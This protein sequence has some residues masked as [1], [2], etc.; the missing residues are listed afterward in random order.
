MNLQTEKQ[1]EAEELRQAVE[2]FG[3]IEVVSG[4]AGVVRP[5]PRS[6]K[7]DPTTK[8]KRAKPKRSGHFHWTMEIDAELERLA[9]AGVNTTEMAELVGIGATAVRR[10]L[11]LLG[12]TVTKVIGEY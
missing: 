10:R 7:I 5:R 9:G 1:R 4:F 6:T 2:Q 12:L 8:L 3:R 11:K